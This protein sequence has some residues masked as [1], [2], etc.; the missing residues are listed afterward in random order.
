[1]IYQVSGKPV[2][3]LYGKVPDYRD[4][5]AGLT[6]ADVRELNRG[7]IA[8]GY[9]TRADLLAAGPGLGYFSAA[10]TAA[11]EKYQ[12]ALGITVPSA[13]VGLGQVVFLPTAAKISAWETGVSG[14]PPRRRPRR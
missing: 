9:A 8:L 10:T 12:A 4:M 1:V 11:W 13:T 7:L 6:G 3:L 2:V 5:S 14:A